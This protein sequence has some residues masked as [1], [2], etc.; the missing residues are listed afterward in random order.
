MKKRVTI[1]DVAAAAG[2]SRQTVSRA[3]NDQGEI[4]AA[5]KERVLQA[6][7]ELGYQP[8]R[9]AQGM[10]TRRTKTVALLVS[11]IANP[12][13]PEVAR[14]VQDTAREQGYNVFLCNTDGTAEE[15][16]DTMRLLAAQGVDGI[17]TFASNILATALC[18][19]ADHY[20]PIVVINR[21]IEHAHINLLLVDNEA[22][23]R[24]AAAHFVAAGHT[25]IG[26]LTNDK[27]TMS[28][29][30]RVRGFQSCLTENHLPDVI[31][32]QNEPTIEGGMAAMA[33][34][35]TRWEGVTAVFTYNDLMA[36]GALQACRTLGK[37]VPEDIAL[38]G[39]DDIHL[40]AV[41]TPTLSSVHVDK[42]AIG[43]MSMTRILAML[44]EP[45]KTFDPMQLMPELVLRESTGII[46][47]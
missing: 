21:A 47:N 6:I 34:L 46:E 7:A 22:G 11:D 30:R 8:N 42:Y 25:Q 17:I 4:S 1:K 27:T 16:A 23:A 18:R 9:L 40:A 19:F 26:M 36:I 13:F 43:Q 29:T 3:I 2:V 38:I 15:E 41:V 5:T 44:N 35:L 24:L 20:H 32:V 10:V 33:A 37:R 31:I 14:G 12:F 45:D 39:F 28:Q